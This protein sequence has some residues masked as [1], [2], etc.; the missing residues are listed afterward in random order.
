MRFDGQECKPAG[1]L[2]RVFG[3]GRLRTEG[4]IDSDPP[5]DNIYIVIFSPRSRLLVRRQSGAE[6]DFR[7]FA[8]GDRNMMRSHRLP[9]L[10][11]RPQ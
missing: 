3:L 11:R 9:R 6:E 10:S 5:F 1:N 4:G 8:V 2:P 7:A